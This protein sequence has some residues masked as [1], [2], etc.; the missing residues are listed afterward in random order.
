MQ[1]ETVKYKPGKGASL[2]TFLCRVLDDDFKDLLRKGMR[3][4]R[5]LVT[6]EVTADRDAEM[7]SEP[8]VVYDLG[9]DG[10]GG[11]VIQLAGRR[12]ARGQRKQRT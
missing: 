7:P 1:N 8:G 5:R 12:T 3:L 6:L 11:K 10:Q 4:N 2:T 9:D